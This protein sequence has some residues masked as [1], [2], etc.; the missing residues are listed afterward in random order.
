MSAIVAHPY[1]QLSALTSNSQEHAAESADRAARLALLDPEQ[2]LLALSF[3][4]GYLPVAFD[5]ALEAVEPC[6]E[7]PEPEMEPFCLACGAQVG[8]FQAHGPEY[9]HFKGILSAVSKPRPYKADHA[10]KVAWRPAT[11]IPTSR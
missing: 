5:A 11:D 4:S 10:P 7:A 6:G 1:G 2:L 9:R 3:L 8:I